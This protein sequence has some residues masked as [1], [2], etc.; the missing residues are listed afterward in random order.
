MSLIYLST[1][2]TEGLFTAEECDQQTLWPIH[3]SMRNPPVWSQ[4]LNY[5][6]ITAFLMYVVC[7]NYLIVLICQHS[8]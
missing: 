7:I 2:F 3:A 5:F 6:S 8:S 4:L 1:V